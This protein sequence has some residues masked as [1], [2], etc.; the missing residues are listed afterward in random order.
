M[1]D[2][3]RLIFQVFHRVLHYSFENIDASDLHNASTQT[4]YEIP[5][6]EIHAGD[7][8]AFQMADG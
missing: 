3:C 1:E 4:N 6:S 5:N 2:V 8:D 7:L